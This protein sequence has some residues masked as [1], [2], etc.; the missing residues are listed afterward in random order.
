MVGVRARLSPTHLGNV[1]ATAL[2]FGLR[3]I[4]YVAGGGGTCHVNV[5]L[6]RELLRKGLHL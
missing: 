1:I 5:C 4:V 3:S 2:F 6:D